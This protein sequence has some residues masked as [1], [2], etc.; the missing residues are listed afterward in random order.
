MEKRWKLNRKPCGLLLKSSMAKGWLNKNYTDFLSSSNTEY[1]ASVATA[2][3]RVKDHM[4]Y[5][6]HGD[7]FP[8]I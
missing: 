8:F 1:V 2:V 6:H 4:F 7:P 5:E 3:C